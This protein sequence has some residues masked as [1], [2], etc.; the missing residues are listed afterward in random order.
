MGGGLLGFVI[1]GRRKEGKFLAEDGKHAGIDGL[2]GPRKKKK[3]E[4]NHPDV[5]LGMYHPE[6]LEH[7]GA[8]GEGTIN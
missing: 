4:W 2:G 1:F 6:L 8:G 7:P 3:H 5:N